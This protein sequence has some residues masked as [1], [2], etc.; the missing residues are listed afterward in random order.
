MELGGIQVRKYLKNWDSDINE[1]PKVS[2]S[3]CLQTVGPKHRFNS[4]LFIEKEG[5]DQ[6]LED[7]EISK[8]YDIAVMS[9]KGIPVGAAC[10]LASHLCEPE[11]V[12]LFVLHDFDVAGFKIVNTLRNGTR[13]YD[14]VPVID[15]GLR[16]EDVEGLQ[17]EPVVYNQQADPRDY[18]LDC[19]ATWEECEFLVTDQ[20]GKTWIG[21]RVELNA[22][23]SEQLII[24]LEGKFDEHK[25]KKLVPNKTTLESA[26]KRAFYCQTL[27]EKSPEI[28][29][30]VK[31]ELNLRKI[32]TD[33]HKS[34]RQ[35]LE[36]NEDYSWDE[37]VWE[38]VSN[39]IERPSNKNNKKNG[40]KEQTE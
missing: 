24:L 36:E 12:R 31:A 35:L 7:A 16:L 11:G 4:V 8:K 2:F 34:V 13:M 40:S 20:R 21:E 26:F 37:A 32:P 23:T 15:L 10:E 28:Q 39:M 5:F 3:R 1:F 6:I 22:M 18:L 19:G 29:K 9:T 17:S 14:G 38:I 33:L 27:I 30:D 25:V